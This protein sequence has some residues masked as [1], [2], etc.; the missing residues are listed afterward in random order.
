M[1]AAKVQRK[2]T[3]PYQQSIGEVLAALTPDPR[4]G[5]S[6]AETQ[7]RLEKYGQNE[8]TSEKP[9]P[10]WSDVLV[11]LLLIATLISAGLWLYERDS[12]LPYEAMAILAVVLLNAIMGHIQGS[13]AEQALAALR[14]IRFCSKRS[15]W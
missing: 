8:L 5:L 15:Q 11:I 14:Q 3:E 7:T 4:L 13:R 12:T 6:E 1:S 10:A 9:V 2:P